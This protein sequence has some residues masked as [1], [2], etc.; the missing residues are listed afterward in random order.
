MVA[1]VSLG[2]SEGF[3]TPLL[4]LHYQY[5]TEKIDV[6]SGFIGLGVSTTADL[7]RYG[8][9]SRRSRPSTV[10]SGTHAIP[11]PSLGRQHTGS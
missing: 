4:E 2:T 11:L 8:R 7:S 3:A 6:G 5:A 10:N 9:P 1:H